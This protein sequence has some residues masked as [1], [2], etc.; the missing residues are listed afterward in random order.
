VPQVLERV[1]TRH[2][3][4]DIAGCELEIRAWMQI[5]GMVRPMANNVEV[6]ISFELA[7]RLASQ[8]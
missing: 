3:D 7:Y 6:E 5:R 4:Q 8:V 2:D 1:E